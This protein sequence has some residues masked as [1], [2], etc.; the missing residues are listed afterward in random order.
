PL[1]TSTAEVL[2]ILP[3]FAGYSRPSL[4]LHLLQ[5]CA[6]RAGIAVDVL[7]ANLLFARMLGREEYDTICYSQSADLLG[8]R[9]FTSHLFGHPS[10]GMR[11][12]APTTPLYSRQA[13]PRQFD[14]ARRD[15]CDR[16]AAAFVDL[17]ADFA[18]QR[19]YTVVGCSTTFE[20]NLSSLSLLKA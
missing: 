16:V 4:A 10:F 2:L 15:R 7:Y 6:A 19:G 13:A 3:P 1:R 11:S 9:V 12:D 17:V 14:F 20:Q 5:A 18:V 8:D